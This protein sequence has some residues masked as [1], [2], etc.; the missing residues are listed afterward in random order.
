MGVYFNGEQIII[1]G[2]YSAIDVSAMATK[3]DGSGAKIMAL[4]GECTGGEPGAIQ[5]ISNP[6]KAKKLL[7]S[8]ELLTACNKAWNPVSKTKE[9]VALGGANIIA[10]IRTNAGTKAQATINAG[11]LVFESDDWNEEANQI[12]VKIQNGTLSNT[13][14]VVINNQATDVFETYDNVGGAFTIAYTGTQAY[15]GLSITKD[16]NGKKKLQTKIGA[17]K[18]SASVDIEINLDSTIIKSMRGLVAKLQSYENYRVAV[19]AYYNS[20]LAVDAL[21][22]VTDAN[23]K[24]PASD[25]VDYRVTDIYADLNHKLA[26]SS[27]LINLKSFDESKGVIEN[28]EYTALTGGSNGTSPASWIPFF[29]ALTNYDITYIVPLTDDAVVH[30][31]LMA[32]VVAMSGSKGRE[33]RMIV[34]GAIGES[35]NDTV[36]RAKALSSDRA[37]VVHGGFYD[38]DGANLVLYAPYILA[39]QHAG[40]CAFLEDGEPAT[41]D[42]YRMA[43]PEYKLETDEIETLLLNGCLAFEFVLGDN[44]ISSSYVRLVQ[45]LTTDTISTDVVHTERAVGVLADSLNKEIRKRIDTLFIGKRT[46]VGVLTSIKNT[47]IS[48][49]FNRKQ[50]EQI[51]DYKDV[52]VTKSGTVTTI[53]YSVAPSEPNNFTLITAHYYSQDISAD[54]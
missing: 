43:S 54:E 4:V 46:S 19:S 11:Q 38:Y 40:R 53:D 15:A 3:T 44:S 49:L 29:D 37:Q 8:G 22:L 30:A 33:R 18:D 2:A 36:E 41:H 28:F 31:E 26:N 48:I 52:F 16:S 32:H 17:T 9:G 7:K 47:V 13:K 24:A 42:V 34:G 39:S 20:R 45:D 10:C 1:P 12:Q 27:E 35:I 50:A 5:F 6:V 25:G 23:I 14:K 51:I 21:D